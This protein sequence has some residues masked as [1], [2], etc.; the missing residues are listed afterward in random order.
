MRSHRTNQ[1]SRDTVRSSP[2]HSPLPPMR[3]AVPDLV[4]NSYFP[5]AAASALGFFE[6]EGLDLSV[7]HL[8]PVGACAQALRDGS[9]D[10]IGASA[11]VP[12]LAFPDWAGAKL[13]CAQSQGMYWILVMRADLGIARGDLQALAGRR[14]AA[15]PLVGASLERL[16]LATGIDP[17][18]AG[19]EIGPPSGAL[20]P[21]VNFGVVAAQA[22]A[23][24]PIDGFFANAMGAEL[25]V[26]SGIG[27][28]VLDIRRGDSPRAAFNYTQPAI[29]TT[30]AL[31]DRDPESAVKVVRAIAKTHAALKRA[32]ELAAQAGRLLFPATEAGLIAELVRRDAP[33]YDQRIAPSF[34]ADMCRYARDCGLM[35]PIEVAYSQVVATRFVDLWNKIPEEPGCA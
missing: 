17:K 18:A 29:A 1:L 3:I 26:R 33:Y 10:F 19:I 35:G 14:I 28:V 8:S 4:S 20:A 5:A 2:V 24:G 9:V 21:G 32:P 34:V 7:V 15:V 25:A 30:D 27:T 12:L 23:A 16:L 11:H 6:R 13:V 31:I 22:L